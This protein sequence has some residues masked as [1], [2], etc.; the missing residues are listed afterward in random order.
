MPLWY[1]AAYQATSIYEHV[2]RVLEAD[3][4]I[5]SFNQ[6]NYENMLISP[7]MTM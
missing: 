1:Q 5:A 4:R 2:L 6:S 7:G 3:L